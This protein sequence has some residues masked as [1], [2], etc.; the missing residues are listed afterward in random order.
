VADYGAIRQGLADALDTIP[1]FLTVYAST[2]SRITPPSAIVLPGRPVADYH[3]SMDGT[4]G[5]LTRFP[6]DVLA[7]VQQMAE[8]YNQEKL[9]ALISGTGSVPAALEA[10]PTL[11]GVCL[12][13]QVST[14]TDYGLLTFADSTFVG[15]RYSVEVFAR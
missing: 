11:G 8:S 3:A 13:L 1:T 12:T 6:F 10:D 2:P 5:A 4:A 7:A 15:V 14:A 9:D